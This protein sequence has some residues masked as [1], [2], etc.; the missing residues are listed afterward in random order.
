MKR[1]NGCIVVCST[2]MSN[3]Y[4]SYDYLT[5][6]SII[7]QLYHDGQ[8]SFISPRRL[9]SSISMKITESYDES[10]SQPHCRQAPGALAYIDVNINTIRS[11]LHVRQSILK[12][13]IKLTKTIFQFFFLIKFII[14][15]LLK[16]S[17]LFVLMKF[18]MSFFS[19]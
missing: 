10:D 7:L 3:S 13:I 12:Y 15:R 18:N 1:T 5:S 4:V 6:F 14:V 16:L 17:P 2:Y 11:W 19:K 8:L 9:R